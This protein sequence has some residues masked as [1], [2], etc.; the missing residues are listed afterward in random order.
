[1]NEILFYITHYAMYILYGILVFIILKLFFDKTLKNHHSN[2]NTLVDDFE[3]STEEFYLKF[4][5]DLLSHGISGI[6][7]SDV[8][9]HEGSIFSQRRRYIRVEW[10]EYQYD[11]CA[12]PFGRGFF[13]SWWLLYKNSIVKILISKIPFVGSWLAQKLY[14]VT[15]YR[16]DTASMFMT[17]AQSSVLKVI[18]DITK[19]KGVRALSENERKP[20]LNDIFKR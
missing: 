5:K 20:I 2:W 8:S 6:T 13:I 14:P 12:A 7:A 16:I 9:L 18:D 11:I 15:Y 19:N 4:K 17:Y 10:K 1:M 3:Y